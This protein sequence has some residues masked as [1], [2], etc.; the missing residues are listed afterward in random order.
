MSDTLFAKEGMHLASIGGSH[1]YA[2]QDIL[3]V[4]I[5]LHK[6]SDMHRN[7]QLQPT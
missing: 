5:V 6:S 2:P 4:H 3:I 7:C 1:S